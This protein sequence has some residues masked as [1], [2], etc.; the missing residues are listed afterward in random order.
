M[1]FHMREEFH[2]SPY[3]TAIDLHNGGMIAFRYCSSLGLTA[4]QSTYNLKSLGLQSRW[5]NCDQDN[6][7]EIYKYQ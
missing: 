5:N 1:S 4:D 3:T 7:S 2:I 6:V